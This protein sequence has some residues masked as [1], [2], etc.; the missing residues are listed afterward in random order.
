MIHAHAKPRPRIVGI[1]GGTGLPVLLDGLRRLAAEGDQGPVSTSFEVSAIVTVADSGG[2]TGRLRRS[3]QLPGLGDLRNCVTALADDEF[4]RGLFQHR[5]LD[6]RE[7]GGHALGNLVLAALCQQSG[8]LTRAI[9][10]ARELL[11]GNGAVLP[12]TEED[13]TLVAE[14]ESGETV[15]GE[16]DIGSRG[17]RISRIWL[18]PLN[19]EPA[20]GVIDAIEAADVIVLGPGSLYTSIVPNLLVS[21]VAHAIRESL[22][23]RVFV[24]N[25]MTQPG[26][27]DGLDAADHLGVLEQILG[28]RVLDVCLLDPG[29]P[30]PEIADRYRARGA[31]PVACERSRI[32]ERGAIPLE[33]D[34]TDTDLQVRRHD[35][36]K[37]A[38][39]IAALANRIFP[40][41][42]ISCGRDMTLS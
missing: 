30:E 23:L 31:E 3:L 15:R 17:E 37:L 32:V 29:L 21:R 18:E 19:P 10:Q 36:E 33:A 42:G 28:P 22:A 26:E 9:G 8:S 4:L 25:L 16:A 38:R 6:S 7:L 12:V 11:G 13:V 41:P 35:P 39:V 1:G 34:M 20:P 2:S 14:L 24:C 5:F 27:T 40:P